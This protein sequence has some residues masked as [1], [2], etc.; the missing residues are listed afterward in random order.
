MAEDGT[1]IHMFKSDLL[2]KFD[3]SM[4]AIVDDFAADASL[5]EAEFV[6]AWVKVTS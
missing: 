2:L 1:S 4:R 6:A 3:A 5:F